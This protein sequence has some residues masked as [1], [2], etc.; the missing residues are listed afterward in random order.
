M[1][2]I[3]TVFRPE[4][5]AD[6]DGRTESFEAWQSD[7]HEGYETFALLDFP[8]NDELLDHL[9]AVSE[10]HKGWKFHLEEMP[11]IDFDTVKAMNV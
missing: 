8:I 3:I 1:P 5:R 10:R 7:P 2:T 11:V 9:Q 6:Y 4:A